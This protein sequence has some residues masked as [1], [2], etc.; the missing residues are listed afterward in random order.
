VWG[1]I[2][3]TPA[4]RKAQ[5]AKYRSQ[6]SPAA[7]QGANSRNGRL[8]FNKTCQQCHKLFGEGGSIGPD[9]T[10]SNRG[11]LDYLLMNIIDPSAEVARDFRM[12]IVRTKDERL[13]TGIIVEKT[14]AR[15][16]IQTDKEKVVLA[17]DDVT[18]VKESQISIMP[19]GQLDA[20]SRAEVRDLISY[21]MSKSQVND[22][23]P[24]KP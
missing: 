7:L 5:L 22:V 3:D 1:D 23:K 24:S 16:T 13:I 15:I 10:G 2:R 21:L 20:L 18:S 8:V 14:P 6:L 12:S 9:L 19:E 4:A 17:A 11:D